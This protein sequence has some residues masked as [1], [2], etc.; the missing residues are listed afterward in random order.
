MVSDTVRKSKHIGPT[1]MSM[2][3]NSDYQ[4]QGHVT[5]IMC[6]EATTLNFWIQ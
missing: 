2:E 6:L 4:H 3:Q 1:K 5:I